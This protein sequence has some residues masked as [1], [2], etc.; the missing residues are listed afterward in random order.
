[1]RP[2]CVAFGVVMSGTLNFPHRGDQTES[3]VYHDWQ[4]HFFYCS[5]DLSGILE[6]GQYNPLY[7]DVSKN[8]EQTPFTTTE[9]TLPYGQVLPFKILDPTS[10]VPQASSNQRIG[11]QGTD[12]DWSSRQSRSPTP[13]VSSRA[14][15]SGESL[16][17][18]VKIVSRP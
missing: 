18:A 12:Y 1:M 7:D 16:P 10:K 14:S 17:P 5:E 9:V 3:A 8:L 13:S 4:S 6:I 11:P 15:S 2:S